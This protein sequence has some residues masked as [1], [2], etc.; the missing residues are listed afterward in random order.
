MN[1]KKLK[2]LILTGGVALAAIFVMNTV[3]NRVALVRE[4]RDRINQGA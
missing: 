4:L 3:A 1:L 2:P